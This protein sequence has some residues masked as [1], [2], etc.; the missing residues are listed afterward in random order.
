ML[1]RLFGRGKPVEA[2][3]LPLPQAV[4]ILK[5]PDPVMRSAMAARM[6]MPPEILFVLAGDPDSAVRRSVAGNPSTP[7][8]VTPILAEDGDVDVRAVL[9]NRLVGLLPTLTIEQ[10]GELYRTTVSA[11]ETLALDQVRF[12]REALANTLKDIAFAPS[13]V[14]IRL[15]HDVEQT[16]AEPVLRFCTGLTDGDLLDI[17]SRHPQPWA[18]SAI[19]RRPTVNGPVA[20]AIVDT[21]DAAAGALLLDNNGAVLAQGTLSHMVDQATHV[22]EWQHGLASHPDLPYR[23]ALRLAEYV[24][25]SVMAVLTDRGDFDQATRREIIEVTRRRLA[26][27][28]TVQVAESPLAR[29]TA[30]HKQGRLIE[31]LLLDAVSWDDKPFV[32]AALG[33]LGKVPLDAVNAIMSGGN[34][35]AITALAWRAGLTM[36]AAMQLQARIGGI[37]PREVLN[38]RNG[39]QYPLTEAD[40]RWQ[41]EFV[42]AM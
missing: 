9:L 21:G 39:N 37:G 40:M 13:S 17:I 6:D 38:A 34:A 12:L 28:E 16:V 1:R 29:A 4:E 20:D 18:L 31:T 15:A 27:R 41:L 2:E 23:L 7:S 8:H 35:K 42:G 11:L 33:V 3:L 14:A 30:L 10:H 19:A 25:Q 36:R 22:A 32:N 26:Y 24:D 5:H